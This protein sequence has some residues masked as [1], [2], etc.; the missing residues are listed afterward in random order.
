MSSAAAAAAVPAAGTADAAADAG[1]KKSRFGAR[2]KKL[3]VVIA[4]VLVV[5]LLAGG[6]LAWWMKAQAAKAE[7]DAE[8][9]DDGAASARVDDAVDAKPRAAPT[10]MPLEPFVVNLA[11][12]GVD[13]F[14]QI[15]ITLQV[16]SAVA[17]DELKAYMPAIRNAILMILAHKTSTELLEREGKERLAAEILRESVRPMG[18]VVPLPKPVSEPASA[19][20]V[21]AAASGAASTPKPA[22]KKREP[23][24]RSPVQRVHFSSFI[25]Q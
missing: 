11:D 22:A 16:E 15:G 21:A 24:V 18:I 9:G 2:T 17:V 25:I 13:R 19:V 4:A 20:V 8:A 1:P 7:A 3:I 14:A 5:L 12:K 10:F 23:E 6:G